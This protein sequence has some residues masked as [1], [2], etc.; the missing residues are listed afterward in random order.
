MIVST[1][2]C[3]PSGADDWILPHK[4]RVLSSFCD[5][6]FVVLDRSPSSVEICN[7]F[8]KVEQRES[9]SSPD[10]LSMG[11]DGPRWSEGMLRQQAWNFAAEC[12]PQYIVLGDVDELP[13]PDIADFIDSICGDDSVDVWYADWVNLI[14]DAGHAIGGYCSPWSYQCPHSNKKGLIVRHVKGRPYIYDTDRT[15]HVRMEPSPL[16]AT[17]ALFDQRHMLAPV[18]LIHHRW[19]NWGRWQSMDMSHLAHYTP[20]PPEAAT[21]VR[22]PRCWRWDVDADAVLA[23][24]P[25]PIAVVGNGPCDGMGET[26]DDHATVIRFNNFVTDGFEQHVGRRTSLWV[27]NA[28]EDVAARPFNGDML[29]IYTLAEQ[30][31]RIARWLGAYPQMAY[32]FAGSWVDAARKWKQRKPS[33][34]LVLLSRLIEIGKR[35]C[36]FGFDG[37]TTG[38]Y[39]DARHRHNHEQEPA[40]LRALLASN[41]NAGTCNICDGKHAEASSWHSD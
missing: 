10:D 26:I 4:L 39:W 40:H 33:T 41:D 14:H 12:N 25:E 13:T 20:W 36:V 37:L 30:G 16:N 32:P 17:R 24:L 29:T 2:I 8:D 35:T 34:G 23:G 28:H 21:V 6:I 11:A 31:D 1:F 18:K 19:A 3:G 38:H 22:V 5:R 27:T 15:R 7:A 9:A